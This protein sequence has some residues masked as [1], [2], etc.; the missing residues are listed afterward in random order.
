MLVFKYGLYLPIKIIDKSWGKANL[1]FSYVYCYLRE[2]F[3]FLLCGVIEYA[4][5]YSPA[6]SADHAEECSK[7]CIISQRKTDWGG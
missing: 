1:F 4:C 7:S 5:M 6:D 3:G 2:T